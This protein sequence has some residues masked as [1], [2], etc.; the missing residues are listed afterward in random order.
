[1]PT[2]REQIAEAFPL[3]YQRI[4]EIAYQNYWTHYD[5]DREAH[6][7]YPGETL[8]G[9]FSFAATEEGLNYWRALAEGAGWKVV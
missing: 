7:Q 2:I 4:H 5:L 8:S 3:H 9:L 6:R 1:M